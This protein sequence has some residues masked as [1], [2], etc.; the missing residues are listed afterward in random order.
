MKLF[1]QAVIAIA[2]ASWADSVLAATISLCSH[3]QGCSQMATSVMPYCCKTGSTCTISTCPDKWTL[4]E[5]MCERAPSSGLASQDETGWYT[6]Y[7][8]T[9]EP[10]STTDDEYRLSATDKGSGCYIAYK[11]GI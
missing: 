3:S 7:W 9:C 10:T 5:G 6:T 4:N 8:T 1:I 2:I 11:Q